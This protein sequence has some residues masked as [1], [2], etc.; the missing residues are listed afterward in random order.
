MIPLSSWSFGPKN[1]E[2]KL[3]LR[4]KS[5]TDTFESYVFLKRKH[6]GLEIGQFC[7]DIFAH[8]HIIVH[9]PSVVF[10]FVI[11]IWQVRASFF[12]INAQLID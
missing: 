8:N 1:R 11:L 10:I 3:V 6:G 7:K 2:H 4:I 9:L 5:R 12:K